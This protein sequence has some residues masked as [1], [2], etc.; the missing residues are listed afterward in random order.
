MQRESIN[1]KK[2]EDELQIVY[3]EVYAPNVV[4][5]QG[6]WMSAVEIQKAAHDFL[7]DGKMGQIDMH[8]DQVTVGA[9]V[10]ESWIAMEG[11]P[12]FIPGSW[13]IGAHVP[14]PDIWPMIKSNELNGFSIDAWVEKKPVELEIDIPDTLTG[15]TEEFEGHTHSFVV[16][17]DDQGNF[18][19]G[20]TDKAADGHF[21]VI[22]SGTA[23]ETSQGHKHRFSFL[24][25]MANA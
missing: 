21:H 20:V 7:R 11:D 25:G 24:E 4:D 17:Y 10:V 9:Y 18:I 14:D 13:V 22:A 2:S 15:Q 19:G 6:D 12:V 1:V 3:G 16:K 5:S 8:H 23:T